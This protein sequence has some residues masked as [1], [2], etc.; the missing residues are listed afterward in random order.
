[1]VGLR[2]PFRRRKAKAG[3]STPGAAPAPRYKTQPNNRDERRNSGLFQVGARHKNT[4]YIVVTYHAPMSNVRNSA[5]S[6]DSHG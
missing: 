2:R 3:K 4:A 1:M 5:A 6:G